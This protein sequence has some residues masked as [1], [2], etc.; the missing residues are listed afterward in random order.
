MKKTKKAIALI[1]I[2]LLALIV[3]GCDE[4]TPEGSSGF[5]SPPSWIHGTWDQ[6]AGDPSTPSYTFTSNNV[7][8]Y[9]GGTTSAGLFFNLYSC[10]N[11]RRCY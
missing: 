1:F 5:L 2:G 11:H 7:Q 10:T 6:T 3:I 8:Y 4:A 9:I